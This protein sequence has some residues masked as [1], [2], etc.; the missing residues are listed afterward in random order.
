MPI[1]VDRAAFE[2]GRL[3]VQS[4]PLKD[5]RF[6]SA[7]AT[8]AIVFSTL[9]SPNLHLDDATAK[10]LFDLRNDA[11]Y[12]TPDYDVENAGFESDAAMMIEYSE[13][14]LETIVSTE[15][16]SERIGTKGFLK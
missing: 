9:P 13:T 7:Y 5:H 1:Y 8:R 6:K 16:I 2:S 14:W 4:L 12:A 3:G 15:R 10:Q 11:L